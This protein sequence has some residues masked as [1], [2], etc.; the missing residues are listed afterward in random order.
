MFQ[1]GTLQSPTSIIRTEREKARSE[2][3]F[4]GAHSAAAKPQERAAKT[5]I[6]ASS[7]PNSAAAANTSES[8]VPAMCAIPKRDEPTAGPSRANTKPETRQQAARR[9][10]G[11]RPGD[12]PN[13]RRPATGRKTRSPIRQPHRRRPPRKQRC[14]TSGPRRRWPC[15]P[16]S[17]PSGERARPLRS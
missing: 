8:S 6:G 11:Q 10:N 14:P 7:G 15:R 4:A 1:L 13:R 2:R 16:W 9:L 5:P 12:E 3:A 17:Q